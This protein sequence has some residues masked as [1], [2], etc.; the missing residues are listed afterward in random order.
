MSKTFD[1]HISRYEQNKYCIFGDL[2]LLVDGEVKFKCKTLE[3]P[4]IGEEKEKDL[5]IPAG[6]YN[7][8]FRHSPQ[9][10]GR[11]QGN[12]LCLYNDLVDKGRYILIHNGNYE[13]DTKGCILLGMEAT[14]DPTGIHGKM[15]T[16]SV[17]ICLEFYNIVRELDVEG[18]KVVI[19]NNF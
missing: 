10:S 8:Q 9:F 18:S 7:V 5:A 13:I 15:V 14:D 1:I 4:V 11:L 16:S 6:V 3:N 19:E 12:V 2:T 17:P